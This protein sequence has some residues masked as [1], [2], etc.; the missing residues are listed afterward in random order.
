MS[1]S[2]IRVLL[3]EDD[4]EDFI[5]TRDLFG[6]VENTVYA[7]DWVATAREAVACFEERRHDVYLIDY[8]FGPSDGLELLQLAQTMRLPAPLIM[9]TGQ[10][11]PEV[12]LAAV[13]AGAADFLIKGEI[14]ARSLERS[15]RYAIERK[16]AET[17]IEKLA[18]FPRHNP[19]PV[20]EFSSTGR[21]TY[22]NEAA[23]SMAHSIGDS[24]LAPLL[25]PDIMQVVAESLRTGNT[26][27][28][29]TSREARTFAWSFVPIPEMR[30]VHGYAS[31]ITGRLHLEA[32]LRHSVKMEAVGQL[33]AGV[34]H[35][36]NNILTVIHG[37]AELLLEALEASPEH[38]KPLTQICLS[39]DK[40]GSLIRQ[41]LMFSRRQVMQSRHIDL[42]EV[43][44][45]VTRMLR[46]MMGEEIAVEVIEQAGLP[47]VYGDMGMMEQVLINLAVNARDAMRRGGK[48]MLA[49]SVETFEDSA[50]MLNPDARAGNFVRLTVSDTGCGMDPITLNRIFE[51]FFTTKA[52]GKG[53]GLGLATVYAIVQQHQGWIE[54][55]SALGAGTTFNIYLPSTINIAHP[56]PS[57]PGTGKVRGG[58][59]TIL[60]VEDE[61][62]LREVVT[63]I[64]SLYGYQVLAASSGVEAVKVWELHHE[65][66]DLL[67]TDM[68]MPEGISGR[69]L[70]ERLL[71]AA[72]ALKVVYTSGYSPGMSGQDFALLEGFNFLPKP[73]PPTRLAEMVRDCLDAPG[74]PVAA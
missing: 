11:E 26:R 13:R 51:P 37:H 74:E 43:I 6:A 28:F 56:L 14:T 18:A 32:Q 59:E 22:S 31:E 9:L 7:V 15:V 20:V 42:N 66:I 17:A 21:M 64:L 50:A 38:N 48:L 16:H 36:F 41:L 44:H 70:G 3:V 54:V 35:D 61:A 47:S 72:P 52:V 33:A 4:E 71:S 23:D 19:N 39:A 46:R 27:Q 53:T 45:N 57:P 63:E 34:A 30:V 12:D 8:R 1:D 29:Q 68:V 55:E 5:V 58:D 73:Y 65:S 69:E 62:A 25:P 49:T 10:G 2:P 40:A 24:S 60:V 67:L